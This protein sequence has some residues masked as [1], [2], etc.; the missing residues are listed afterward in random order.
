M[1]GPQIHA[2]GKDVI[3]NQGQVDDLLESL[4]F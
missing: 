3:A 4:G 2:A 1:N